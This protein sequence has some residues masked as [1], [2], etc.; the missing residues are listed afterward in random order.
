MHIQS[1]RQSA[2]ENRFQVWFEIL[3]NGGYYSNLQWHNALK[4]G[5]IVQWKCVVLTLGRGNQCE[6]TKF[7]LFLMLKHCESYANADIFHQK[8]FLFYR[9]F[10]IHLCN[11]KKL[12]C[13]SK[14]KIYIYKN[15]WQ[16]AN[17][18][19]L[20]KLWIPLKFMWDFFL[21]FYMS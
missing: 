13:Q 6:F 8:V 3:Q 16:F 15:V 19:L 18:T 21:Q 5:K 12:C 11:L 20:N 2:K 1:Q 10:D 14:L 7:H 4:M 9:P 17:W